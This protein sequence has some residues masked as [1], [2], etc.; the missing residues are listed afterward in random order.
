MIR[1]SLL[2]AERAW[3]WW[4]SEFLSL[5][6]RAYLKRLASSRLTLL[7]RPGDAITE[8]AVMAGDSRLLQEAIAYPDASEEALSRLRDVIDAATKGKSFDVIGL[9]PE[10]Q[11]L[12][13]PLTLPR[14]AKAHLEETVRYQ[15]E[16]ISPFKADNTLYDIKQSGER[17]GDQR[18]SAQTHHRLQGLRHGTRRAQRELWL[19]HRSLRH[20]SRRWWRA[21]DACLQVAVGL[22]A[23]RCLLKQ[24]RSSPRLLF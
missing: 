19:S 6:P 10:A 2:L 13:R 5:L 3:R 22:R 23:R 18:T 20:R 17:P 15:I 16:R 21:R 12:V 4:L 14:A 1:Q 24:R 11:S 7:L 8:I 9:I